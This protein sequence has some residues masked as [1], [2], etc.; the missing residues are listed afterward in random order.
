MPRL[1]LLLLLALAAPALAQPAQRHMVASANPHASEAGRQVLRDGGTAL[2][3]G[4]AMA[5]MLT[6]VEP[7]ASGIGGGALLLHFDGESGA[8]QAWDGRETAP[9]A[10]TPGLFLRA[11][12]TPMPFGAAMEGGRS[13]GVPGLLRMLEAAH[14][15]QGSLPWARLIEPSIRLAEAGFAI[16]PRLAAAIA[17]NADALRRDPGARA[18][19]FAP[20]GSPLPAGHLLRNPALAETLRLVAAQGAD[21]LHRGPIAAEISA[22]IR[23]HANPGGMTEQ[24]LAGYEPRRRAAVCAPYRV[25]R[26]CGFGPPSSGG[27]AVGQIL[28]VLEHFDLRGLDPQGA[29]AAHLLGE[30]GRLAFAD[31]NLYLADADFVPVPLRGL[32]DPG[33][34]TGRAQLVDRNRAMAP[35]RAGNPNWR[36]G[37]LAP[38]AEEFGAGTTHIT[39]AD[40]QGNAIS[41]TSTVEAVMA[42]RILLR[43]FL[44]NN[45]LTDFSF[46]PEADGRP[47]ANRVEPGKRPRSSMSPTIVLNAEGRPEL[48]VGSAGGARIIGHVAQALVGMLDWNLPPAEALALPR[49]GVVGTALLELEAGTP[50]AALAPALEARG[51]R[52]DVR[53]INSGLTAIRITPQGMLGAADPRREGIA[54]GD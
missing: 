36:E 44:L 33:Y 34:L 28:G 25:W 29:D 19:F 17:G 8:V 49:V 54:L 23:G 26:V 45:E 9:A 12:G 15:E 39:A 53:E 42:S 22:A 16:S 31:R 3:A 40:A 30:A 10:A 7:Q 11:D 32:L 21:A 20:D 51:H 41:M 6:L 18:Y 24:D 47:V 52:T 2:D 4:I 13:V 48:L 43:G 35:P 27:V 37:A 46:A 5:V 38:Q 50:A 14:R 1:L